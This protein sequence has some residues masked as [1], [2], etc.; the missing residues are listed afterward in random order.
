MK[1][2]TQF[3][4]V[5]A[6]MDKNLSWTSSLGD[7]YFN[8][9]QDVM[10]AVQVMRKRAESAGTL[11]TTQQQKVTTKEQT[12]IIE[13]TNPQVVYLPTYDPWVVYG[14]RWLVYPGYFDVS[15]LARL[16]VVRCWLSHR[17]FSPFPGA[18]IS[19]A[20]TGTIGS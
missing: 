17:L 14:R 5:L 7:A 4:S 16:C 11:K 3:P 10:D 12:I 2:L 9:P 15:S 6:N 8:H 1:A 13:P 20:A 19:G 18:G